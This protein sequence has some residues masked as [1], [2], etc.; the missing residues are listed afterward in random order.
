MSLEPNYPEDRFKNIVENIVQSSGNAVRHRVYHH[1][2]RNKI[3]FTLQELHKEIHYGNNTIKKQC[4]TLVWLGYLERLLSV[5]DEGSA[6]Q[7]RGLKKIQYVWNDR[8]KKAK[9]TR[10]DYYA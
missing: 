10:I 1:L 2:K 9:N 7:K 6:E 4:E 3:P 8:T 5:P